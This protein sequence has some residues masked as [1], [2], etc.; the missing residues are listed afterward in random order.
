MH[1]SLLFIFNPSRLHL[2]RLWLCCFQKL[3]ICVLKYI[4]AHKPWGSIGIHLLGTYQLLRDHSDI[5]RTNTNFYQ[6]L[7]RSENAREVENFLSQITSPCTISFL[8]HILRPH[9]HTLLHRVVLPSYIQLGNRQVHDLTVA[10]ARDTVLYYL[11]DPTRG[12]SSGF[13]ARA[14]YGAG[15]EK[16]CYVCY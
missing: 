16:I 4:G 12:G 2:L 3:R 15:L 7:C 5:T 6:H 1:L 11:S 8:R 10:D 14:S 13:T 9:D